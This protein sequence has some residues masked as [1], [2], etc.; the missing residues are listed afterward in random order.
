MLMMI[1]ALWASV[2]VSAWISDVSDVSHKT[3][4]DVTI[5]YENGR[6][7]APVSSGRGHS[8]ESN[9]YPPR[10]S[11]ADWVMDVQRM[12]QRIRARFQRL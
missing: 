1:S 5:T 2:V 8:A 6:K 12:W 11:V 7:D 10:R 9:R 4:S 3:I